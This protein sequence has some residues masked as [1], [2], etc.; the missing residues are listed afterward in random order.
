MTVQ[1]L[2]ARS[3]T[4]KPFILDV[5]EHVEVEICKIDS[6]LH[7]P[8]NEIPEKIHLLPTDCEIVALCHHGIRSAHVVK[9][10]KEKGYY[11]VHNLEGGIHAWATIIDK[12][13]AIY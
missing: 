2:H 1:E 7:I 12:T 5:R 8:M 13:M 4:D 3:K 10:L 9:F 6:A 11:N